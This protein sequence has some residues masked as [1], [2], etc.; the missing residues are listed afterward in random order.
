LFDLFRAHRE[1]A[2]PQ[3]HWTLLG[4]GVVPPQVEGAVLPAAVLD[5]ADPT[6]GDRGCR[7]LVDTGGHAR[8]AYAPADGELVAVRPDGHVGARGR[9]VTAVTG[10]L[11]DVLP[12]VHAPVARHGTMEGSRP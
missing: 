6:S 8:A 4:F 10:W 7:V 2:A 5:A 1:A 11:R 9:D 12:P 3:P